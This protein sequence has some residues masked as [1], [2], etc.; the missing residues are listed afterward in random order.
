MTETQIF[1]LAKSLIPSVSHLFWLIVIFFCIFILYNIF[2]ELIEKMSIFISIRFF[3]RYT[4]PG[5]CIEYNGFFGS[6]KKITLSYVLLEKSDCPNKTIKIYRKIL[7]KE[8]DRH[9]KDYYKST[10]L[11][12]CNDYKNERGQ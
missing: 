6:I 7:I 12:I 1:V 8:F 5:T 9:Y 10:C 3:D 2:K 11:E 4:N